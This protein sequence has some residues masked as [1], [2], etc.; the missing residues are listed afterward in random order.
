[1]KHIRQ[2]RYATAFLVV[3]ALLTVVPACWA[4]LWYVDNTASG[5]NNGTSWTDAW[6]TLAGMNWAS[7]SAG[8]TIF[9]SGGSTSKTYTITNSEYLSAGKSGTSDRARIVIKAGQDAGHNG[10]VIFNHGGSYS[11]GLRLFDTNF[12]T[13][14]GEY[15]GARHIK[16]YN[17]IIAAAHDRSLLCGWHWNGVKVLY[18]EIEKA[19]TGIGT[20]YPNQSGLAS[21]Q[22]EIAHC[23]IHDIQQNAALDL[24]GSSVD[25]SAWDAVIVH[26]NIIEINNAMGASGNGPDGIQGSHGISVYNNTINGMLGDCTGATE[27]QDLVQPLGNHWKIYN[28]VC[29]NSCGAMIQG[30]SGGVTM[31]YF[32]VYNNIFALTDSRLNG[33]QGVLSYYN[34][35][36]STT[37]FTDISFCHN[38]CVDFTGYCGLRVETRE[39][40]LV[41]SFDITIKNNIFY[42]CGKPG[43]FS[44]IYFNL[45][46]WVW[47]SDVVI[48]YNLISAG[49]IGSTSVWFDGAQR[50]QSHGQ[51]GSPSPWHPFVSYTQ[52]GGS[53]DFRLTETVAV[54]NG[55]DLSALGYVDTDLLGLSRPQ[56]L[57]WDMGA[58]ETF[59]SHGEISPPTGL[60]IMMTAP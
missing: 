7:I 37:A 58:C 41:N 60:R 59:A 52:R 43:D 6:K 47:N 33:Y 27:H 28:N 15:N 17:G 12:V 20:T 36:S 48:D 22:V 46:D 23:Y 21:N 51:V 57:G 1:M 56:G 10:V 53:N 42:N 34:L 24:D 44:C 25:N 29:K 32:H 50:S 16:L 49:A 14:D 3:V 8:D 40:A 35:S 54:D 30:G 38:T 45:A 31:G 55:A 2:I 39:G 5:A 9:I 11:G 13:I 18:L 4:T 19:E 26:D